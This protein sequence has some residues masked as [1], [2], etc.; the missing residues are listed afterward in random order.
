M[1]SQSAAENDVPLTTVSANNVQDEY[2]AQVKEDSG[3]LYYT[4][5]TSNNASPEIGDERITFAVIQPKMISVI[6]EQKGNTF[7]THYT[8]NEKGSI[9]IIQE[10][11]LD[12]AAMYSQ[13]AA[14]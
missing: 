5:D 8:K 2:H 1:Y 13:S 4:V 11:T 6:A 3:G 14:E 7:T 9:F 10:G 12:A